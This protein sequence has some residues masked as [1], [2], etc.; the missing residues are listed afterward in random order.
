VLAWVTAIV[1]PDAWKLTVFHLLLL[2]YCSY[3]VQRHALF[4]TDP[5]AKRIFKEHVRFL[6]NR[7]NTI[8]G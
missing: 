4:Y 7:N 8:N 3:E 5:D 1:H 6:I 2:L